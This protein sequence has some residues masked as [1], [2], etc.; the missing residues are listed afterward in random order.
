MRAEETCPCFGKIG[1][2]NMGKGIGYCGAVSHVMICDGDVHFC[3]TPD[4]LLRLLRNRLEEHIIS[5]ASH[6][7]INLRV[8]ASSFS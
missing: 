4:Q 1:R 7:G 5:E 8:K 2:A 3:K 6:L